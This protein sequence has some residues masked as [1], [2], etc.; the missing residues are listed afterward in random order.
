MPN[1]CLGLRPYSVNPPIN[2]GR[3]QVTRTPNYFLSLYVSYF[4]GFT[5]CFPKNLTH[6]K[7]LL[8]YFTGFLKLVESVILLNIAVE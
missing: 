6:G 7:I 5:C 8:Y 4:V 3:A 1:F 2:K